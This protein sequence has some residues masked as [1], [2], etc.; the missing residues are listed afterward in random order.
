MNERDDNRGERGNKPLET[1]RDGALKVSIFRNASEKGN[2]YALDPGRIYTDEKTNEVREASSLSGSEPLRMANLLTR[3]YERIGHYREQDKEQ[4]R[5]QEKE[6]A[7]VE[8]PSKRSHSR[9][10]ERER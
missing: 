5:E 8:Q 3:G 10:S 7:R 6:R 1:L 4:A 2:Y 9:D